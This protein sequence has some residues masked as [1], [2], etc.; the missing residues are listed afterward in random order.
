MEKLIHLQNNIVS[1]YDKGEGEI[2]ILLH[3]FGED[4]SIWENQ[5]FY[6][7][8]KYRVIAPDLPGVGKST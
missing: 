8:N 3:G 6:L 4:K 1:Y 7:Q 2:V 5:I